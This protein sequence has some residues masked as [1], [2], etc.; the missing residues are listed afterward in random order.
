MFC[1]K[2]LLIACCANVDEN[3]SRALALKPYNISPKFASMAKLKRYYL[4]LSQCVIPSRGGLGM[5]QAQFPH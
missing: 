3:L 1:Y 4:D 5:R 2:T